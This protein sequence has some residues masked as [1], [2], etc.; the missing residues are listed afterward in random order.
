MTSFLIGTFTNSK[1]THTEQL[2]VKFKIIGNKTQSLVQRPYVYDDYNSLFS[3]CLGQDGF[4]DSD[5]L[6]SSQSS[7]VTTSTMQ[8][9]R[10]LGFEKRNWID[11]LSMLTFDFW[12]P[13]GSSSSL[14]LLLH[15]EFHVCPPLVLL[16]S[17]SMC[18]NS[19]LTSILNC[20]K[21]L[22]SPV[23]I[24][25]QRICS[26]S[27]PPKEA[28]MEGVISLGMRPRGSPART[29]LISEHTVMEQGPSR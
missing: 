3:F 6:F 14:P 5:L 8:V 29:V 24:N 27:L 4:E 20:R 16:K 15:W 28:L 13:P 7:K 12:K 25:H 26:G 22:V 21:T 1:T 18:G 17:W 9:S 2:F 11:R 19:D 23:D 10:W